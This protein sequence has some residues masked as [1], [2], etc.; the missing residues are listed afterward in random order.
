LTIEQNVAVNHGKTGDMFSGSFYLLSHS[1]LRLLAITVRIS[2]SCYKSF[3]S[4]LFIYLLNY[5]NHVWNSYVACSEIANVS[6]RRAA[7][8]YLTFTRTTRL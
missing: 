1:P 4:I 7:F 2:Y 5:K 8:I 6:V 3:E